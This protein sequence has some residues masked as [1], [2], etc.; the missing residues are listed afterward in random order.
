ML[1]LSV[2]PELKITYKQ[3]SPNFKFNPLAYFS[4]G[5]TEFLWMLLLVTLSFLILCNLFQAKNLYSVTRIKSPQLFFPTPHL[6]RYP[7]FS[8]DSTE[9]PLICSVWSHP[10]LI[11]CKL[12]YHR[13]L[14]V[15]AIWDR[16][17]TL[18]P[19]LFLHQM[20]FLI[21]DF[22]TSFGNSTFLLL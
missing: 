18:L 15:P 6:I 10:F 3:L 20:Q 4:P 9:F 1:G 22:F 11:L 13:A 7:G 19:Q 5:S 16:Q 8:Q 14:R 21:L 17:S 12:F 2:W